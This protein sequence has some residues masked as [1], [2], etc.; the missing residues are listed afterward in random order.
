MLMAAGVKR[1]PE[2][3]QPLPLV[4]PCMHTFS[5]YDLNSKLLV[6]RLISPIVIPYITRL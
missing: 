1:Y 5:P 6:P 2:A 4:G 3:A